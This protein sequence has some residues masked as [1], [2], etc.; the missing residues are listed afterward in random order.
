MIRTVLMLLFWAITA[1]LAALIG[2]PWTFISGDIRLLYFLFTR[3]AWAGVWITGVRVTTI[4]L[5]QFDHARS[6]IFMTN[7]VSNLDPPIQIS[8]IPRRS[9]VMVKKELFAYPVLGRAMR[10]GAFVPVD[11]GN[12]D[13]G[14]EA[15]RSAKVAVDQGLNMLIY[16]EGKRSF[17]GKLLPFKKGPF[18]LAMEC[19]VPVIPI[20]IVGTHEAMP[21]GRFAI[22]PLPVKVIFHPPIEPKD[23]VSRE[24]LM[25]K[26]RAVIDSGLP[27]EY[28][29]GSAAG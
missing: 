10:M 13:A 1:P 28:R 20:T 7:H 16:I 22:L 11:R 21:K 19:G 9:S 26:V 4:G 18:Y 15:V 12:R 6:Y 23:F 29:Q 5:D 27:E 8:L 17:D 3:G 25:E 24:C 14:I 2:F